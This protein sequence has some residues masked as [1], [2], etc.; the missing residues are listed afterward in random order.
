MNILE[1]LIKKIHVLKLHIYYQEITNTILFIS[2]TLV[3]A[4]T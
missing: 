4:R 3:L 1:L 2:I